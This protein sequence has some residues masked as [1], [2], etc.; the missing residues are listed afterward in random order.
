[1]PITPGPWQLGE[2]GHGCCHTHSVETV[3]REKVLGD[4]MEFAKHRVAD[5]SNEDDAKA[6]VQ[7][8][9]LMDL[10]R[11]A[12]RRRNLVSTPAWRGT[13]QRVFEAMGRVL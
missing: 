3:E 13:A 8:H 1:M 9:E 4:P 2:P 5:V 10:V 11:T 12:Y 7:L 6:I